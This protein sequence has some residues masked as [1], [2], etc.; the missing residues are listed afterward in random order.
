MKRDPVNLREVRA[1]HDLG[2]RI[3]DDISFL[4]FDDLD[5]GE[6][7]DPPLTVIDRPME[8]QG[9]LAMRLLLNRMERR[10]MGPARTIRL[11]TK[12]KIRAS[13][14]PPMPARRTRARGVA[15]QQAEDGH[16]VSA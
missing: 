3:P 10:D 11:E 13:C 2:L 12:L 6:L 8:E 14:A 15:R 1:I 16:S 7:L 4:G 5:L 9:V